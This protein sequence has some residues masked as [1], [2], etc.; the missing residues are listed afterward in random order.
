MQ[1]DDCARMHAYFITG[2]GR[3]RTEGPP[4]AVILIAAKFR[5]CFDYKSYKRTRLT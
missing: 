1:D 3:P 2:R 4:S 5:C